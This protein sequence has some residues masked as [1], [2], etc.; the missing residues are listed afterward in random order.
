MVASG[1][2]HRAG[3]Y[4]AANLLPRV[5]EERSPRTNLGVCVIERDTELKIG[6]EG[7]S[8]SWNWCPLNLCPFLKKNFR[9]K[10]KKNPGK[11]LVS[12]ALHSPCQDENQ[13]F[14]DIAQSVLQAILIVLTSAT[15]GNFYVRRFT[16][17]YDPSSLRHRGLLWGWRRTVNVSKRDALPFRWAPYVP[18]TQASTHEA[19]QLKDVW[20]DPHTSYPR[21]PEPLLV[22]P[23]P[24]TTTKE[25]NFYC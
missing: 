13:M 12:I 6:R 24:I 10:K 1:S 7:T 25:S 14:C 18:V 22:L 17:K 5:K 21:T 20:K 19:K 3:P 11:T 9:K 4:S 2:P 16:G 15:T 8:D 23:A